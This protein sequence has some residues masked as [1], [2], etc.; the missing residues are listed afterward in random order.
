MPLAAYLPLEAVYA[1]HEGAET[2]ILRR[3]AA[4]VEVTDG[5]ERARSP[6]FAAM[7]IAIFRDRSNKNTAN[8]TGGQQGPAIH[9][10]YTRTPLL[11]TDDQRAGGPQPADVLINPADGSMWT[12][13]GS[14]D[15]DE[16][17]GYAVRVQRCGSVT[18][19]PWA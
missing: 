13:I 7:P 17:R 19:G 12:A 15:W 9:T 16:A 6:V 10:I 11:T 1:F 8:V 3:Y 18:T 4:S 2:W 14:G 5:A